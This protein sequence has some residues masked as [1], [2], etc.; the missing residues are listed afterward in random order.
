M[1]ADIQQLNDEVERE[2][3]FVQRLTGEVGRVIVGQQPMVER[4]LIGLLCN[5]HVLL[6][7][8]PGLAKT[9]TIT[10]MARAVQ[11]SFSRIQ[12]TPDLLPAD[13]IGTMIYN[14]ATGE[15]V[16]KKGPVFAQLV[17]ADEVNRAPAKVQSAMLEAMQERQV[18]IGDRTF[19]MDDPFLVLATQNP[20]E[21]EGTYPLPEAQ[22]DRFMM[23]VRVTYPR[24]EEEREII[25]RMGGGDP[26]AANQVVRPEDIIRAR[27]VVD[28]V[29]VDDK[30]KDYIVDLMLA[31]RDPAA[32]GIQDLNALIEYGCSPRGSIFLTRAAKAHAFLR[33][34]GYVTPEDVKAMGLDILRHRVIVTYEAEAE[35]VDS[36]EIV[37]RIFDHVEVP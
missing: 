28:R 23:K 1:A 37:R 14:Q 16:P 36:E 32:F 22:V 15:F 30:I 11:A 27:G 17:L 29:Y 5:G 2:S 9:L 7:G 34:R 24:R 6:E 26:P 31:T 13:L 10:T 4:L 8:V 20:I 33:R 18:T 12:F 25:D 21:Q 3:A 19:R 35:E